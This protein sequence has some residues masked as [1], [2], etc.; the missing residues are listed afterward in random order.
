LPNIEVLGARLAYDDEGAGP[1]VVLVHA[2]IA[3]RRMWAGLTPT[4]TAAGHRVIA[5]D[6]RG[7]GESTLSPEPPP[8]P[9]ANHDDLAALL[10]AL[11]VERA[12]LV[13]C[14]F[15]GAVAIDT[16]LAHPHL[17]DGL[18]LVGSA[19]SGHRLVDDDF[20]RLWDEVV[21]EVDE[22]DLDAM[23]AAEVRFWVV[24]P[25]RRP[26]D[27]DPR[28]IELAL[29]LDRGA[30]A[31]EALVDELDSR[32]LEPPA[33]GRLGEI[34]VP[35][36][37]VAGAEDVPAILALAERLAAGL[38]RGYRH[39]DIPGAAHLLPLERPEPLATAV[40]SFLR[41]LSAG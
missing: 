11:G 34:G 33:A 10:G 28:L 29:E 1:P 17:V 7:Y 3:D 2:G 19:L 16:A 24:G 9:F 5:Y 26:A 20:R 14:S 40:R 27:V 22:E 21:G 18:V 12:T 37:V 41:R 35:A 25:G 31:A 39:P 6:L 38:A 36:L 15:G 32:E 4:L 23:A 30:L 8:E 13:G